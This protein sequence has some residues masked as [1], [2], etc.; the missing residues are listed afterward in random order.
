[1]WYSS[2]EIEVDGN[3]GTPEYEYLCKYMGLGANNPNIFS[4][5]T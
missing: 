4:L 2:L 3:L 1:M 5:Y